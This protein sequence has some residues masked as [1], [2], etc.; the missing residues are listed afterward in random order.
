MDAYGAMVVFGPALLGAV[1][2]W[3]IARFIL[4]TGSTRRS[5]LVSLG[6]GFVTYALFLGMMLLH[7]QVGGYIIHCLPTLLPGL[8]F[9]WWV[10]CKGYGPPA[11]G[12]G[13]E[14][15]RFFLALGYSI[16]QAILFLVV[17]YIAVRNDFVLHFEN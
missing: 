15:D 3:C 16:I 5:I 10:L 12:A 7:K 14:R 17:A 9:T 6:A 2:L 4:H 13:S 11:G 8:L 1:M